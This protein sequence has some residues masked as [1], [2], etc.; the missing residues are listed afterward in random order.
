MRP[1]RRQ[2]AR[3][4]S[5]NLTASVLAVAVAVLS[6]LLKPEDAWAGF[7]NGTILLLIVAFL[8]ANAVVKCG[9]GKRGGF[10]LDAAIAPAFPSITA[11]S[12]VL[13]PFALTSSVRS[14]E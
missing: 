10:L 7:G 11:R 8:V 13:Y 14:H 4:A 2:L 1:S 3:I 6:G 12:G 9:L 5:V